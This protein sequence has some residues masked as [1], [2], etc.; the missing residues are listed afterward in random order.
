MLD[1]GL[2]QPGQGSS[3]AAEFKIAQRLD[4]PKSIISSI[5]SR[6]PK[7]GPQLNKLNEMFTSASDDFHIKLGKMEM[8]TAYKTGNIFRKS[9]KSTNEKLILETTQL[10]RDGNRRVL[11]HDPIM[12]KVISN[13]PKYLQDLVENGT[14]TIQELTSLAKKNNDVEVIKNITDFDRVYKEIASYDKT[15]NNILSQLSKGGT[16]GMFGKENTFSTP[17]REQNYEQ[18]KAQP[19]YSNV[20]EIFPVSGPKK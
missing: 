10:Y 17:L 18:P 13:N 1:L 4:T 19:V 6:F 16:T 20:R 8:Y 7:F 14:M 11:E 5:E 15:V 12:L 3:N 2:N 9:N